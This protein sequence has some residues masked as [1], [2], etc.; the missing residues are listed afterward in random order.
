MNIHD[1]LKFT[2]FTHKFQQIQRTILVTGMNRNEN[3]LEHTGQLALISWYIVE[4]NQLNMDLDKII[5]YALAHDLVEAY[6]GDTFAYS[7]NVDEKNSKLER[8]QLAFE[9]IKIEFPKFIELH[10]IIEEYESR[11]NPEAKFIYSLDKLIPILNVYL[12]EGKSWHRDN[13]G[14]QLLRKYKDTKIAES[15]EVDFLWQELLILLE[16]GKDKLFP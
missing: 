12:D 14:F 4:A 6:A 5:K 7:T 3:D 10:E 9:K 1:L 13:I 11:E 16:Q 2:D 8:E 15:Q